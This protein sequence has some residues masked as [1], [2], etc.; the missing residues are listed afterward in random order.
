MQQ[1]KDAIDHLKKPRELALFDPQY[2][3]RIF[4]SDYNISYTSE[5]VALRSGEIRTN[6]TSLLITL[7]YDSK[8]SVSG[9][10]RSDIGTVFKA[11]ID[12]FRVSVARHTF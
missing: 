2:S 9:H 1:F 8:V 7:L 10:M 6:P 12:A 3:D 4:P 11:K 5:A